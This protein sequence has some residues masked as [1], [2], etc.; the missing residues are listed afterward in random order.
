MRP[1]VVCFYQ[2]PNFGPPGFCARTG[3]QS[4]ALP[5]AWND[6]ISSVRVGPLS[7]GAYLC[8]DNFFQ[9]QCDLYTAN[10]AQLQG[11][12]DNSAS[13]I[14][15]GQ[16][17]APPPPPPPPAPTVPAGQVCF[18]LDANYAGTSFCGTVGDQVSSIPSTYNNRISSARIGAGASARICTD[19]NLA[20]QCA[21]ISA[22]TPI[23][24][25]GYDNSV[26]SYRIVQAAPPPPPATPA[27]Q[28]C[29][30]LDPNYAGPSF[31]GV[32]GDQLSSIPATL[33]NRISSVRVG[34][35]A[36]ARVCTDASL[37]GQ[38]T[39]LGADTPA[40]PQGYNDTISSYR[41]QQASAPQ[42]PPPTLPPIQTNQ[43]CFYADFD[44]QGASLC[45]N[46]GTAD[47]DMPTTW[48]NRVSSMRI[49]S[50]SG[51]AT[52]C[53]EFFFGGQC[54]TFTADTPRL[55]AG[56]NDLASS[57]RVGP[58]A[59]PPPPP[60]PPLPPVPAGQV[61]FYA[62]FDF[63]GQSFCR[64][65]GDQNPALAAD[66]N[67]RISSV[68]MDPAVWVQVCPDT[69]FQGACSSLGADVPRLA[70]PLNDAISSYR[71]FAR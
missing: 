52:L 2:N 59:T 60:P 11:T 33:N 12:R 71:I 6:R 68:R 4:E 34:A 70:S 1:D 23:L 57:F 49:G 21:T 32:I 45:F 44:Y 55:G 67:N 20:G 22:D 24:P 65:A 37:L 16:A 30:Y 8:R 3:N 31:C 10:V 46:R 40:M 47:P 54:L 62:D 28:V 38:C 43:A 63:A 19:P 50:G 41:I 53:T 66:W 48:D 69:S 5:A 26:S 14:R 17:A 61:C 7:G 42:P 29:F 9:G 39:T 35:G 36:A 58:A 27:G 18:Y 25:S 51:G 15:V 13:S 64:S 56:M